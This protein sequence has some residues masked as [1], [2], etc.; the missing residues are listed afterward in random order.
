M[1]MGIPPSTTKHAGCPDGSKDCI[2]R[3]MMHISD[4]YQTSAISDVKKTDKPSFALYS[5][6]TTRPNGLVASPVCPPSTRKAT[7]KIPGPCVFRY[8]SSTGED[9]T[10]RISCGTRLFAV[11]RRPVDG[12]SK[13]Q[14]DLVCVEDVGCVPT[15]EDRWALKDA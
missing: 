6:Q 7:S 5:S 1:V 9:A 15:T 3:Q 14:D 13:S 10:D 11:S 4:H 2:A 12:V 8:S